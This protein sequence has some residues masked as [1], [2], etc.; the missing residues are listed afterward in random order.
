M[1]NVN[2]RARIA[3]GKYKNA[4]P[5]YIIYAVNGKDCECLCYEC[6]A[7]LVAKQGRSGNQAWHFA[8]DEGNSKCNGMSALHKGGTM[9]W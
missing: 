9:K 1:I 8:H 5:M 2:K 6:D 7:P 4:K 3:W